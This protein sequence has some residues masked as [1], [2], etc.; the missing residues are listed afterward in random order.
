MAVEAAEVGQRGGKKPYCAFPGSQ[1]ESGDTGIA[2]GPPQQFAGRGG[3][4]GWC[5]P[6]VKG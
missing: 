3:G 6:R 5:L 4:G 1:Q 2:G